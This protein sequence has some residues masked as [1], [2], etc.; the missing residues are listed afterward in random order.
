M[1]QSAATGE[2]AAAGSPVSPTLL[3]ESGEAPALLA[4]PSPEEPGRQHGGSN[5]GGSSNSLVNTAMASSSSRLSASSLEMLLGEERCEPVEDRRLRC[6]HHAAAAPS[7]RQCCTHD[8]NH[9]GMRVG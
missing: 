3:A 7:R 8:G 6:V 1:E 2:P 4:V 9:C 5:G